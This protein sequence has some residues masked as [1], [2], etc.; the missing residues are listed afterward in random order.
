MDVFP[1]RSP[2]RFRLLDIETGRFYGVSVT[3]KIGARI[4]TWTLVV[5]ASLTACGGDKAATAEG[6]SKAEPT[7]A[8]P[9]EAI[10]SS[11]TA[12]GAKATPAGQRE[13]TKAAAGDS[14]SG[15]DF[16]G[17]DLI[18][19]CEEGAFEEDRRGNEV[20]VAWFH[21]DWCP[22]C[23][24]QRRELEPLKR[25]SIKGSP[26]I[27]RYDFDET[28]DLQGKLRVQRQSSFIRFVGGAEQA[29]SVGETGK[30][31]LIKFL[32]G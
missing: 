15:T 21:A 13:A 3:R 8:E 10:P 12:P 24:K 22:S 19:E 28:E 31:R 4:L 29:R 7:K 2:V 27:C 5:A 25:T 16:S 9:T 18:Y 14:G 6:A 23:E 30:D 11:P 26:V 20:F 1:V 32:E 17:D